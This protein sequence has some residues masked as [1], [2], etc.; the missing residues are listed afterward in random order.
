MT[1]DE[2]W[3]ESLGDDVQADWA[4]LPWRAVA[5][6]VSV[7]SWSEQQK[8]SGGDWRTRSVPHHFGKMVGHAVKHMGGQEMDEESGLPSLAHAAARALMC[9]GVYLER[10]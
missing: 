1:P 7:M 3:R 5:C 4:L 2:R 10:E 8:H 6:V 9:C